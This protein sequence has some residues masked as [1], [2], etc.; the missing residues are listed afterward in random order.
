MT[1]EDLAQARRDLG[2]SVTD[3]AE[4]L[5]LE[6]PNGRTM[7]RE[8]ESGKRPISGP[9]GVAVELMLEA[10]RKTDEEA[11][12]TGRSGEPKRKGLIDDV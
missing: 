1:G 2:L 3:L 9:I 4:R 12:L 5:R 10:L 8:M 7:V 11:W 6:L